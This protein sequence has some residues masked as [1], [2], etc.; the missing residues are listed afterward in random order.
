MFK[1]AVDDWGIKKLP[2]RFKKPANIEDMLINRRYGITI[3]KMFEAKMTISL[4]VAYPG[5]NNKIK[6]LEKII[7]IK[8]N[9]PTIKNK[10]VIIFV[11]YVLEYL[12]PLFLFSAKMGINAEE[13]A[14]SANKALN[15]FGMANATKKASVYLEAP[16]RA[17][18]TKSL[19]SPNILLV[20][21][22]KL[23]CN[24]FANKERF[25]SLNFIIVKL[26]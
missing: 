17:A 4:S 24:I 2:R 20:N 23:E 18:I 12:T 16:K 1:R 11:I 7:I 15:K 9:N 3:F 10:Y 19:I 22:P 6:Y 5:R 8:V 13:S 26:Q 14:P 21:T 25:F